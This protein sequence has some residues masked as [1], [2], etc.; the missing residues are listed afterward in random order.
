[1]ESLHHIRLFERRGL[2]QVSAAVLLG[3]GL[4]VI[5]PYG[6]FSQLSLPMRL[7]YWIGIVSVNWIQVRIALRL[8]SAWLSPTDWPW[9]ISPVVAAL[10]ATL[11]AT[12]EVVLLESWLR[13]GIREASQTGLAELYL[14][15]LVVTLPVTL[16]LTRLTLP[17][18]P[19]SAVV[20]GGGDG[21]RFFQ[22]LPHRLGRGLLCLRTED[23]YLRVFTH[24]GEDL[25]LL[26]MADAEAELSG[27]DGLRVHRSW[28]VAR[29][30]LRKVERD[31]NSR[32]TLVLVND[33]RVPVSRSQIA[34]LRNAGWL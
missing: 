14:L 11:P 22:R 1:M 7:L 28:W 30:A 4:A 12:G 32:V 15:V 10:A 13:P 24:A 29:S 34:V 31:G 5:G 3:I 26:R 18:I 27:F 9:M 19:L 17:V 25:I 23:H 33:M 20:H 2:I 16:V 8:A 6:T 21:E